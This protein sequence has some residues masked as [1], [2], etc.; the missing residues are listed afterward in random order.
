MTK[1]KQKLR[2]PTTKLK[3]KSRRLTQDELLERGQELADQGV[4]F[5]WAR[6]YWPLPTGGHLNFSQHKYMKQP[7]KDM[8]VDITVQKGAQTTFSE[9]Q[10]ARSFWV[11]D[12]LKKNVMYVFPATTQ[13]TDFVQMRVDPVIENSPYLR[14]ITARGGLEYKQKSADKMSLKR[15]GDNF[16]IFRGGQT[17]RQTKS[18]PADYV[19]LDE[20]DEISEQAA[21][22]LQKRLKHSSL[23]WQS[24]IST[25]TLENR[26]INA[27]MLKTDQMEWW[28][29]CSGCKMRQ[30]LNYKDNIDEDEFIIRCAK[31]SCHKPLSMQ[32][33]QDN[34]QWVAKAPHMK[35]RGYYV[36][37]LISPMLDVRE[38]VENM[39]SHNELIVQEC[40][41]QDL[42]LPYSSGS[43]LVTD[44]MLDACQA[45]YTLPFNMATKNKVYG[46]LDIGKVS[47]LI[48]MQDDWHTKKPRLI[49]AVELHD[50]ESELPY[51]M[52][53][54]D[55][56]SLVVDAMPEQN[57]VANLL[58]KYPGR[59][60]ACHYDYTKIV[61]ARLYKW[62]D[63]R[64]SAH[65]TG[66]LDEI[67]GMIR[68]GRIELPKHARFIPKLY[69]Q[70]QNQSRVIE[71][72][73]GQDIYVYKDNGKPDHYAHALNYAIMARERVPADID[74]S[75]GTRKSI[76]TQGRD[77]PED[78]FG[79]EDNEEEDNAFILTS[80][81]GKGANKKIW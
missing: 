38:L 53:M 44:A 35:R 22:Q 46:G 65:R 13:L 78:D 47:N 80:Q 54:Y 23:R 8:S 10:L 58:M 17:S 60:F 40:W 12:K 55:V 34:G 49:L 19:A 74:D 59:I 57:L 68:S 64:V 24:R 42:G 18:A 15:V 5:W 76:R 27:E 29:A 62:Y 39:N 7:Y 69:E 16:V 1:K 73:R 9:W 56:R 61:D 71:N 2:R 20:Y 32:E 48:L 31:V 66:S 28:V 77:H 63:D 70:L 14:E 11:A 36:S 4:F 50:V 52:D 26:G 25:P 21:A 33:I 45:D 72:V 81:K 6:T 41:N 67:F 3:K 43:K 37:G 30:V 51:F 75:I 79:D